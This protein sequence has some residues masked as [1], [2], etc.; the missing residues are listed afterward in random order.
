[1]AD[2]EVIDWLMEGDPAVRWQAMRD[3]LGAPEAEVEA[4]R[5]LVAASGWGG[6]LLD[7]Q[8]PDGSWGPSVY[9]KWTGTFYTLLVLRDLGLREDS[10]A[11]RIAAERVLNAGHRPADGGLNFGTE[12]TSETCVS[13]MGLSMLARFGVDGDRVRGLVAYL[14]GEHMADGG[15]NCQRARGATHSSFHTTISALEGLFELRQRGDG[16]HLREASERGHEFLLAH[17]LFRSHRTGA[18]VKDEFTR[19]HFPPRWHYDVLRGLDFLR[20]AGAPRDERLADAVTLVR[21][22]RKS[23]GCWRLASPYRGAEHFEME[24][25]GQPSRWN[26]LRAL[27]VLQ[28]WEGG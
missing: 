28:W 19:F 4:E 7:L 23:D 2:G 10:A 25:G 26:T 16:E 21:E 6:R 3:L 8:K 11:A 14:L 20:A 24:A 18:V 12:P 9:G 15:W 17:R 22:R 13:G 1:M 27:R 5:K